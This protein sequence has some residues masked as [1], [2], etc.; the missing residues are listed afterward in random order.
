ME[1]VTVPLTVAEYFA[2]IGLV[3]MGLE[4][5]G[6]RVGFA[7]DI[8]EKKYE[9]YKAFFPDAEQHYKIG[10]VF[11]LNPADISATMLA[12][13]SFPCIDLSLAGNMNGISC[14]HRGGN[15]RRI[16]FK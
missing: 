5:Y 2:G 6:W 8:S 12:T 7:N 11:E 10:D 16:Q 3:R 4:P 9:M 14:Q 1:K 15:I 13:C